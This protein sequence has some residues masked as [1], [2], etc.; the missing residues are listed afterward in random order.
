MRRRAR[1]RLGGLLDE[2]GGAAGPGLAAHGAAGRLGAGAAGPRSAWRSACAWLLLVVLE[3]QAATARCPLP[4]HTDGLLLPAWRPSWW[5]GS[6]RWPPGWPRCA[7]RARRGAGEVG[8]PACRTSAW[9]SSARAWSGWRWPRA[10]A[11]RQAD[12]VLLERNDRHGP[13][14]SSRNSEVIHAGM[15]YPHGLAEGAPLRGGQPAALRVL[16]A[17]TRCPTGGRQA[18]RGRRR[19][20][21]AGARRAAASAAGPTAWRW[22]ASRRRSA[23]AG[24]PRAVRGRAPLAQHRHRERARAH[25]CAAARRRARRGAVVQPRSELVA[26][27]RDGAD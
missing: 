1:P 16:R 7:A 22:S 8:S 20:R 14:T 4:C 2:P 18:H 10:W 15:Y 3:W 21:A 23:R 5:P 13:E 24:A 26:L 6:G 11:R 12:L 9:R 27:E 17:R 19:G 25:G